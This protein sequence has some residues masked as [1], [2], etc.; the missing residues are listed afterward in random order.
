MSREGSFPPY[1]NVTENYRCDEQTSK[2]KPVTRN[3]E[4][5]IQYLSFSCD[6]AVV[7]LEASN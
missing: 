2:S 4:A 6:P 5:S 1:F 3:H 7:N